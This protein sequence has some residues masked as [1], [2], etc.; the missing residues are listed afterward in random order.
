MN[1]T[2]YTYFCPTHG[3]FRCATRADHTHCHL[4]MSCTQPA[5]RRWG[6]SVASSFQPH[7]NPSLGVG[8][9]SDREFRNNLARASEEAS[10]PG[11][12]YL[13]DGTPVP[14]E[15]PQHHFTPV[16]MRDKEALGVTNE[17]LPAT[18]DRWKQLGRHDDA[19]KLKDLMDD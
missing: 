14:I 9:N 4:N 17:G 3:E 19:K 1:N 16:D 12:N 13:A 2:L 18:Y 8:V 11:I 15:R 7:F 6:F 10:A 5:Q